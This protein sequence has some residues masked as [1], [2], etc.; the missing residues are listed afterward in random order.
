VLW[1]FDA[2]LEIVGSWSDRELAFQ[3]L[4]EGSAMLAMSAWMMKHMGE[5]DP[6]AMEEGGLSMTALDVP[7]FMWKPLVAAYMRGMTFVQRGQRTGD[8]FLAR[9][10][11]EP[12]R[13]SEQVLHPEKYWKEKKRDEPREIE[14]D[15][16]ALPEGWELLDQ[17]TLGEL[18]CSLVVEPRDERK[19]LDPTNAFAILGIKYTNDAAEGWGGDRLALLG[20]GEQRAL[21]WVTLWDSEKD[22]QEFEDALRALGPPAD[23]GLSWTIRSARAEGDGGSE[24]RGG[25]RDWVVLD[26]RGEGVADDLALPSWRETTPVEEPGR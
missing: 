25:E 10:F 9:A 15:A 14:L 4:C 8:D 5:L 18:V 17:D 3:S 11:E 20:K 21:R 7:P 2:T 6:N 12:P 1:Y 13:S 24:A 16:S 19:G 22:A 23:A 26:V